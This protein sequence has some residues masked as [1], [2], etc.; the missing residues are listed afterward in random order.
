[1]HRAYEQYE[2]PSQV[3]YTEATGAQAMPRRVAVAFHGEFQ[4]SPPKCS[5]FFAVQSNLHSNLL[6]PLEARGVDVW[7]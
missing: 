5:N 2:Q 4:R 1:M 6:K 3:V 7:T